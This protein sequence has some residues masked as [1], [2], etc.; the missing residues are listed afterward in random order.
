[1]YNT[2]DG[3]SQNRCDFALIRLASFFSSGKMS[4]F[5]N[6]MMGSIHE[7]PSSAQYTA[8]ASESSMLGLGWKSI[9]SGGGMEVSVIEAKPASS[10]ALLFS[11][12]P[13]CSILT[14]SNF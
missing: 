13:I 12:L 11:S 9:S 2:K 6:R 3:E 7:G 1:M 4:S 14:T 5:K 10:S 8:A